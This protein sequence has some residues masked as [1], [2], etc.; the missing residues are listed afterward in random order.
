MCK[1]YF[2][3]GERSRVPRGP[4]ETRQLNLNV[5]RSFVLM[6][7]SKVRGSSVVEGLSLGKIKAY[8]LMG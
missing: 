2:S 4:S 6:F 1:N 3:Q 5:W 7:F 8:L